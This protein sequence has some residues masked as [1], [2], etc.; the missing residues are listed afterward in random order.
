MCDLKFDDLNTL[1]KAQRKYLNEHMKPYELSSTYVSFL[2][3]LSIK[4]FSSQNE[5]SNFLNCNKAHTTRTLLK[6]ELLGYIDVKKRICPKKRLITLTEKGKVI[7]KEIIKIN[8]EFLET[9]FKDIP[10]NDKNIFYTTLTK[11]IYNSKNC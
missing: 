7:T 5:L 1:K 10:E 2:E 6:L 11:L 3:A 4:E 8:N 9:I